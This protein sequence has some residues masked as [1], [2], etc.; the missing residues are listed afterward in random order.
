MFGLLTGSVGEFWGIDP[1]LFSGYINALGTKSIES[2][3]YTVERSEDEYTADVAK[4]YFAEKPE[5]KELNDLYIDESALSDLGYDASNYSLYFGKMH[6]FGFLDSESGAMIF[7][8]GE[9]GD[10]NTDLTLK[11]MKELVNFF[12]PVGAEDFDANYTELKD[13]TTDSYTVSADSARTPASIC[14][15][16]PR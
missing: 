12:Q 10:K 6:A 1:H 4:V 16:R 7:A 8:V 3:V 11:S 14:H 13:V 2:K 9:Y 15:I 5:M